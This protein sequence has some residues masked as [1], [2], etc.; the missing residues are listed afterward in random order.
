MFT[1]FCASG[2]ELRS[3]K[4]QTRRCLS[5]HPTNSVEP[6]KETRGSGPSHELIIS[7]STTELLS[8][9]RGSGSLTPVEV[10]LLTMLSALKSDYVRRRRISS[11]V[12]RVEDHGVNQIPP[13]L[14]EKFD[15][16]DTINNVPSM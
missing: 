15:M 9:G 16:L 6:L 7:S 13:A 10:A 3:Q 5:S 1:F 2:R 14:E 8:D 4:A 11:S 12:L